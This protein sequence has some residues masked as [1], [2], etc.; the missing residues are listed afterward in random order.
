MGS[1]W[2]KAKVALGCIQLPRTLDE[3][4]S[5]SSAAILTTRYD[6]GRLSDGAAL[7]STVLSPTD[8]RPS[9]VTPTP[10]SSGLRLSR[11]SSKSSKVRFFFSGFSSTFVLSYVFNN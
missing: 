11:T 8:C 5:S 3:D 9:S 10:S 7:S 6:A 2:R 4:L 1:K